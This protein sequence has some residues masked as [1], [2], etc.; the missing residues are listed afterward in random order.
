LDIGIIGYKKIA[1]ISKDKEMV[2]AL[3]F[4]PINHTGYECRFGNVFKYLRGN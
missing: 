3:S 2:R 1:M 4:V